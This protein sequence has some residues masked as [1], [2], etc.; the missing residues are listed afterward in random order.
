MQKRYLPA[1]T[2]LCALALAACG[3]SGGGG[4]GNQAFNPGGNNNPSNPGGNT[5]VVSGQLL[6]I[7]ANGSPRGTAP[8]TYTNDINKIV[9]AGQTIELVPPGLSSNTVIDLN[10]ANSRRVVGTNLADARW[11]YLKQANQTD[12]YLFAHGNGTA[13]MPATGSAGYQ[14]LAIH[15][16]GNSAAPVQGTAD[17]N[18]N[19][20]SKTLTGTVAPGGVAPISLQAAIS[21]NTFSGDHNGVQTK[22][23]FYG[24]NA[25]EMAGVYQKQGQF[26]GAFGAKKQ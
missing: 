23:G 13:Q 6:T 14:G 4:G 2:A 26:S 17:F 3:S 10:A 25:A 18:V 22:G 1:L 24:Q 16:G 8:V 21:G 20:G 9:I 7:N 19:F 5:P 15:R 11:G 12:A